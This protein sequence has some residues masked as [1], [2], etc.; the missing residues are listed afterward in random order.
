MTNNVRITKGICSKRSRFFTWELSQ[1]RNGLSWR[2]ALSAFGISLR[3]V[4]K[5]VRCVFKFDITRKSQDFVE[6]KTLVLQFN[7]S[8]VLHGKRA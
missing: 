5:G 8:K 1:V 3:K 4:S 2:F 6:P 7:V